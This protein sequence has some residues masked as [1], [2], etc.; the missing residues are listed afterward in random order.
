[1]ARRAIAAGLLLLACGRAPAQD[2]IGGPN[3]YTHPVAGLPDRVRFDHGRALFHQVWVITPSLDRAVEGLG[4]LYNQFSCSACHVGNGS[5]RAPD[6]PDEPMRS[7]L[8][9][10]S[11]PGADPHGGPRPTP[12]YGDQLNELGIPGVPGEGRAEMSWQAETFR[13]GDGSSVEL[14]RPSYRFVDLAYGP[15]GDAMF[16]PRVAPTVIGTGL[17]DR[18]PDSELLA[19][20]AQ[21]RP[22][23][24]HGKVNMAWDAA[25]RR[26]APGRFGWKANVPHLEQQVAGAFSGDMGL[27]SA[28]YP[29]PTCT[30]V[31]RACRT[32][33][34]RRRPELSRAQVAAVT[35]YVAAL[36]VPPRGPL[37]AAARRGA[38][39]FAEA[40]CTACHVETLRVGAGFPAGADA[41][42]HPYTDL[43]VHD[44]G[45]D[46]A[47][48][49]PDFDAGGRQWRTPPLW[50]IGLAQTVAPGAG[51][52]HDGRAR[53]IEEAIVWH[54]GEA[55]ASRRRFAAMSAALRAELI[56]FVDS[57]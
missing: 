31:E 22:D 42:I 34:Q 7:M 1:M 13:Y 20:A 29:R 51:F 35:Y 17:L 57:L 52:L 8:V 23:G 26:R 43:L 37:S 4:P 15:L 56:A 46:L 44:M 30:R 55:T 6:G 39:L 24:V 9:R 32:A 3:A 25:R 28:L 50:G 47:D 16:S 10:L 53:T 21:P 27:T 5:G 12:A 49:R 54:G 19:L 40:G 48:G 36:A 38:T 45:P 14:R 11:V 2:A 33:P 41:R 18:V